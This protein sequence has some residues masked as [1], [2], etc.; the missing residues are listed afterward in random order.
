MSAL[1]HPRILMLLENLPFPQD[2]R[3]RREA[4]ALSA[5]GYRVSLI[6]PRASGQRFHEAIGGV[7]VYRYPAPVS[8][9]GF[10]GYAWEYG[11]AMV[12]SFVLSVCVWIRD[13][14]DVVH[15]H[16]PPDTFVFI[17]AFYKLFGKRFVYDHHDLSPEM[18][19]AKLRN[20]GHAVVYHVLVW[21]E[22]R[23]PP[24]HGVGRR[25][26]RDSVRHDR[27]RV[28]ARAPGRHGPRPL[29]PVRRVGAADPGGRPR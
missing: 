10:L 25:V 4:A 9:T 23:R 18:Y 2:F 12:A 1:A 17:A 14:F 26:A 16:N 24:D 21:L 6:C 29:R 8:A 7:R 11:Y 27:S 15:A 5:G 22:H 19:R 13:G 3:V 28:R 20:G